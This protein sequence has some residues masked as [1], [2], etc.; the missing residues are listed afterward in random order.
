MIWAWNRE[1]VSALWLRKI[2]RPMVKQSKKG[3]KVMKNINTLFFLRLICFSILPGCAGQSV[4]GPEDVIVDRRNVAPAQYELDL[5][6][7]KLFAEQV[8]VGE[9]ATK[10]AIKGAVVGGAGGAVFGNSDTAA[11]SATFT[12]VVGGTQAYEKATREQERVVQNC[13]RGRG[14]RVLN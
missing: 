5:M 3:N 9:R 4:F 14:Y 11:R 12:G 13:L 7:C 2:A 6:E 10:R 8:R 1:S